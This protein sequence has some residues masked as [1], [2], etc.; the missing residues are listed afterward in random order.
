M[1]RS[2]GLRFDENRRYFDRLN[3]AIMSQCRS[4]AIAAVS[5]EPVSDTVWDALVEPFDNALAAMEEVK[6]TYCK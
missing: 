1:S 4:P 6:A 5:P 2:K 3:L